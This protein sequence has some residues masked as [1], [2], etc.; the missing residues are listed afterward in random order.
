MTVFIEQ[1][2]DPFEAIAEQQRAR[3]AGQGVLFNVRRP[4]RGLQATKDVYAHLRVV[5]AD[6]QDLDFLDSGATHSVKGIGR[7]TAYSNF[8]LQRVSIQRSELR[9]FVKT[10]GLTYLFLF[11]ENPIMVQVTGALIHSIDFPW[12]EE[13]WANYE[14]RLRATKLAEAGARAY[15]CY[16]NTLIEG[17]ILEAGTNRDASQPSLAPLNFNMVATAIKFLSTVG[18]VT[19][20]F[21]RYT[22]DFTNPRTSTGWSSHLP[23]GRQLVFD[24]SQLSAQAGLM[25]GLPATPQSVV[26]FGSFQDLFRNL[27]AQPGLLAGVTLQ[28]VGAALLGTASTGNRGYP[29]SRRGPRSLNLDE[30]VQRTP[31]PKAHEWPADRVA[32]FQQQVEEGEEAPVAGDVARS[33]VDTDDP[34]ALNLANTEGLEGGHGVAAVDGDLDTSHP[35]SGFGRR[36]TSPFATTPDVVITPVP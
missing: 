21:D 29:Q 22:V 33:V 20:P 31:P 25:A 35:A 26:Q 10:F 1:S 18:T 8:M 14:D 30:Y 36:Q 12:D 19:M 4:T 13:W 32:R 5:D 27:V 9:Q 11:G 28:G 15:L 3:A 2:A 7:T 34:D 24:S 6:G 17:Y 23:L 16:E